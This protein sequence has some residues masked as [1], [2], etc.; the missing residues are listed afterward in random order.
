MRRQPVEE[1]IEDTTSQGGWMYADLFLAL[2]VIFLATVSFVPQFNL[3]P[4]L[5]SD[6][7]APG[8]AVYSFSKIYSQRLDVVFDQYDYQFLLKSVKSFLE[9]NG[10]DG[11]AE[12]VFVQIIG[13]YDPSTEKAQKAI[14]RAL[15]FSQQI[16]K[17][18]HM[19]LQHASTTLS[20]S[21]SIEPTQIVMQITF[22]TRIGVT[23]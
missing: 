1:D 2:M 21:P 3:D 11:D 6:P 20:S 13:G 16:D 17:S 7:T 23:G 18:N 10:I 9:K 4:K 15:V 22:A 14:D 12:I 8:K 19:L 5:S